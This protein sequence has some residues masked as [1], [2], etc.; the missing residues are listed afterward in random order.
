MFRSMRGDWQWK[1]PRFRPPRA[2]RVDTPR[3]RRVRFCERLQFWGPEGATAGT[4]AIL[5]MPADPTLGMPVTAGPPVS[6]GR[7]KAIVFSLPVSAHRPEHCSSMRG[8]GWFRPRSF[9]SRRRNRR[10]QRRRM[11]RG[12]R[13]EGEFGGGHEDVEH[14]ESRRVDDVLSR[15]WLYQNELRGV[16]EDFTKM[17]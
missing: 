11:G 10:R 13:R 1:N 15:R 4:P 12:A 14:D 2:Q 5:G 8:W 17:R 9:R 3:R 16:V 6:M 7:A